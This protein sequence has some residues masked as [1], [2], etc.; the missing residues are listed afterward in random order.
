MHQADFP[1][2]SKVQVPVGRDCQMTALSPNN[3]VY[4]ISWWSPNTSVTI[5]PD[6]TASQY[7]GKEIQSTSSQASEK[8]RK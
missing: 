1:V 6:Q 3:M 4:N 5:E 2:T 8:K 7:H